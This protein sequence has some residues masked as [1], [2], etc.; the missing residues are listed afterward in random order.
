ML[1]TIPKSSIT[2]RKF[3]V[4]KLWN[5]SESEY[6]TTAISGS[7]PLYRS[8][9]S[10]YYNQTDGNV[11]NIFGSTRNPANIVMKEIYQNQ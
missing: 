4:Y 8:I 9:K 5:V 11:F 6:P 2:T 1:K 3:Q 10:K 7:D